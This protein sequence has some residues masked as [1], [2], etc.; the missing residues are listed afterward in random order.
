[1]FVVSPLG[2]RRA[3]TLNLGLKMANTVNLRHK[4]AKALTTNM[5]Y[6]IMA[7]TKFNLVVNME[8]AEAKGEDANLAEDF[9]QNFLM[10]VFD[11]LG[12]ISAGYDGKTG[13]RIASTEASQMSKQFFQPWNGK[14]TPDNIIQLQQQICQKLKFNAD[15]YLRT[16]SR[17][18][19][20]LLQNR[21]CTTIAIASILKQ[22]DQER[23]FEA[24]V[25]W[26][27]DSR[28]YFLSPTK[29]LQQ[30][31]KDDL[32]TPKDAFE[33]LR[34]DP[35]MSQCL[36]AD[37]KPDW[38]IHFQHYKFE[39]IGCFLACTDGCF[40]YVSA[41]GEFEKLLLET[42]V[43][44]KGDKKDNN[45]WQELIT[46]KYTEIKQDDVS[47][48]IYPV[49]F[50][51][52]KHIKNTYKE[53]LE[54]LRNKFNCAS[55]AT[56][57][58]LQNFWE[59][60]RIDYEYY[61]QF[62][63]DTKPITSSQ[64]PVYKESDS[65]SFEPSPS[66]ITTEDT[67]KK[68]TESS[69]EKAIAKVEQIKNLLQQAG[70][71]YDNNELKQAQQLCNQILE[72]EPFSS[73]ANYLLGLIYID[74]ASLEPSYNYYQKQEYFKQA[75]IYLKKI[76]DHQTKYIESI[77]ELGYIYYKLGQ[78]LEAVKQYQKSFQ[79]KGWEK[80]DNWEEHLEIF[81]NSFQS[82]ANSI[83]DKSQ[84]NQIANLAIQFCQNLVKILPEEKQAYIY[85]LI[86]RLYELENEVNAAWNHI[87][88][89]VNIYKKN[90]SSTPFE[91]R[92]KVEQKYREIQSKLSNRRNY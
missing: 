18:R 61:L 59:K 4:R 47:L 45:D 51:G 85:Y 66:S 25:A 19:G 36:T 7:M 13:G 54:H 68:I 62:I 69:R 5:R 84:R 53:R 41:P 35:P 29:G 64:K 65:S 39:E 75:I 31:T 26:M 9:N 32:V 30:L 48:I 11:G 77:P 89:A 43:Q 91:I 88:I 6:E 56:Y 2:L 60:Y 86:A 34:Q 17:L 15:N 80:I 70:Q 24:D 71:F 52:I 37:L 8:V 23:I 81:V 28:I 38:Q 16:S 67:F 42:L 21:L 20:T 79:S 82:I 22:Q 90:L 72:I 10:G 78:N 50:S 40:Q 1:M 33:M 76:K 12:G 74:T 3:N 55:N 49:G 83:T 14:I 92:D 63:P 57:D 44:S 58:E 87:E 73:E 27:G 46:K